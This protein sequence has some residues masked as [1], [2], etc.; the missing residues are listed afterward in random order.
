MM[1]F[2]VPIDVGTVTGIAPLVMIGALTFF[3][4][5][6]IASMSR[7]M[8]FIIGAPGSAISGCLPNWR[9]TFPNSVSSKLKAPLICVMATRS[10]AP[11]ESVRICGPVLWNGR[12]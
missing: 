7:T 1:A 2:A 3:A 12:T 4:A 6:A 5:A 8:I 9:W 10:V 11:G